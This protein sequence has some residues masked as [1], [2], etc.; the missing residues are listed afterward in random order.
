MSNFRE[1]TKID[2]RHRI[3]GKLFVSRSHVV[4]AMPSHNLDV[5]NSDATRI[6]LST[7]YDLRIA[8]LYPDVCEWL[9]PR[10]AG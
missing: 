8:A 5:H 3:E 4:Y 7:G 6:V 1:F 9:S 2:E 10:H